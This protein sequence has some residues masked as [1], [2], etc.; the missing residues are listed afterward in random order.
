[1][2]HVGDRAL[3]LDNFSDILY[4]EKEV[5]LDTQTVE[6]VEANFSFYKNSLPINLFTVSIRV[7]ALWRSI[8]LVKKICCNFSTISS[9]AI[10]RAAA[11]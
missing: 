5:V 9:G 3:T 10:V 1:M 4:K 6:K 7:L 2:V 8:R 11:I